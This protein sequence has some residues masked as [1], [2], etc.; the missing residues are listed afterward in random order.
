MSCDQCIVLSELWCEQVCHV[1]SVNVMWPAWMTCDQCECHV[2]SV[3][4]MWPVW[5]PCDQRECHVTSV[6]VMWLVWMSCDQRECH[7]TSVNAMWPVWMSCDQCEYHEI[8][9]WRKLVIRFQQLELPNSYSA[10]QA[11]IVFQFIFPMMHMQPREHSTE[12][13]CPGV[14]FRLSCTFGC[15]PE[16]DQWTFLL[17]NQFNLDCMCTT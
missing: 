10:I 2:T 1:T 14:C 17:V 6:N 9:A 16:S 4:A 8:S 7:V 12:V 13:T 11:G 5:M 3:N 15:D